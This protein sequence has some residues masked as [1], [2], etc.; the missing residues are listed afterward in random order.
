MR[1][2]ISYE[3]EGTDYKGDL[4]IAKH[5]KSDTEAVLTE[6][7]RFQNKELCKKYPVK[8]L[9]IFRLVKTKK[10]IYWKIVHEFKK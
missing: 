1:Y 3:Y 4:L 7:E 10:D 5:Y 6:L 2:D 8:R 9:T